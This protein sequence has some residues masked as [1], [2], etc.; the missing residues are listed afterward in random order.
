MPAAGGH[1]H[2]PL[3]CQL[4]G[5]GGGQEELEAELQVQQEEEGGQADYGAQD[6]LGGAAHQGAGTGHGDPHHTPSWPTGSSQHY[7]C[8]STGLVKSEPS[9]FPCCPQR[10]SMQ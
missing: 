3:H 7:G 10:P 8:S 6:G 9:G 4:A 2:H 5:V 1:L